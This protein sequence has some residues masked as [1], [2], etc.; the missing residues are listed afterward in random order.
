MANPKHLAI[1]KQGVEKMF[2]RRVTPEDAS[3][4]VQIINHIIDSGAF[5]VF[6]A[7]FTI[8]AEKLYIER[9]T[10]R[11]I[12]NVAVT[13]RDN[14][15]LGFQ[16]MEPFANY[17][18][19]FDHVSVIGTYVDIGHLRQGIATRL[20]EASFNEAKEKGYTKI[21]TY[22]R[23]DNPGALATYQAHGFSIIGTA[24]DQVKI[25]GSYIDEIIVERFL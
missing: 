5:T 13:L 8:E 22:I 18:G 16:S 20:F 24:K 17:T 19:A 12:F 9:L 21:F 3:G 11:S 25:N 15:I 23:A 6:D 1:L 14:K 10:P 4:I 2:V 7:P